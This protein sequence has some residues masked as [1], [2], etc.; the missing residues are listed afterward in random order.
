M[1][2]V[3]NTG[4]ASAV[5]REN[6]FIRTGSNRGHRRKVGGGLILSNGVDARVDSACGVAL[7]VPPRK[8]ITTVLATRRLASTVLATRYWQPRHWQPRRGFLHAYISFHP[9]GIRRPS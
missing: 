6:E 3:L 2:H 5:E 4:D 1:L 7:D 8:A 9:T